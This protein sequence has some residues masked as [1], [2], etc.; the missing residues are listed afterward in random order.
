MLDAFRKLNCALERAEL[1]QFWQKRV[2]KRRSAGLGGEEPAAL[3]VAIRHFQTL[4][5]LLV[6]PSAHVNI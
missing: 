6:K 4:G 2:R 1:L 3:I 5:G